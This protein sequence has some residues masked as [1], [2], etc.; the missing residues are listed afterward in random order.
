MTDYKLPDTAAILKTLASRLDALGGAAAYAA[1][2]TAEANKTILSN[3]D[4]LNR[5]AKP[6]DENTKETASK[7]SSPSTPKAAAPAAA[8][9]PKPEKPAPLYDFSI[10][11]S[12]AAALERLTE[13]IENASARL[14]QLTAAAPP[15]QALLT[16]ILSRP[17]TGGDSG[18]A[19][20]SPAAPPAPAVASGQTASPASQLSIVNCQLSIEGAD[21]FTRFIDFIKSTA[22]AALEAA[23]DKLTRLGEALKP[24]SNTVGAGLAWLYENV[25]A[26]LGNYAVNSLLPGFL[27]MLASALGVVDAV[28]QAAKP[29]MLYL[30]DNF[31][32]PVASWTCGLVLDALDALG[33]AFDSVSGWI[34]ANADVIGGALMCVSR[35]FGALWEFI[36]PT[37]NTWKQAFFDNFSSLATSLLTFADS[38]TGAL[39]GVVAYLAGAFTAGWSKAWDGIQGVFKSVWNGITAV[40]YGAV[41]LIIRGVNSMIDALNRVSFSVPSWVPS[42][43][44]NSFGFSV[45]RIP[46]VAVPKLAQGAVIPA[47]REF[48]AVLGDQRAGRNLEAP[49]TLIRQIVREE[50]GGQGASRVEALLERLIELTGRGH[51]ITVN[52]TVLGRAAAAAQNAEA[53]R[54]GRT[55]LTV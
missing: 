16:A 7:S 1:K 31:L 30:F 47:N 44:G 41:N 32:K 25:L 19:T 37:L 50:S 28:I 43:G 17:I 35:A 3:F 2:M 11:T 12:A 9:D 20:A 6:L 4:E 23:A 49:E 34:A 21:A 38:A 14:E 15:I 54:T 55:P 26:P 33:R 42:I 8:K 39:K 46:E 24:F 5:L 10:I 22:S 18:Q 13:A 53:R 52:E 36:S 51:V 48:L 45:S 40:L 27:D 29:A